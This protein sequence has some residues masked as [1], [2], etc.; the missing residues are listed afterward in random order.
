MTVTIWQALLVLA[1]SL[2]L[3]QRYCVIIATDTVHILRSGFR[4][5]GRGSKMQ[6]CH[7]R[8]VPH[9][10]GGFQGIADMTAADLVGTRSYVEGW[11]QNRG[12]GF[13]SCVLPAG[14][15]Q[16]PARQSGSRQA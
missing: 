3:S 7:R 14:Q 4:G 11:C 13:D 5:P 10:N 12:R 2:A 9:A 16:A 15:G 6:S 1:E 8:C